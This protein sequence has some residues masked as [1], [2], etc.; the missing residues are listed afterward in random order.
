MKQEAMLG[1]YNP[2][3]PEVEARGSEVQ[4]HLQL[5][6]EFEKSPGLP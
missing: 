6:S 4:G 1:T 2:S 5:Y 3:I